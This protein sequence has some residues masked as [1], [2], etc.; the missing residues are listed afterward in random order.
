MPT[1]KPSLTTGP[2]PILPAGAH[3]SLIYFIALI[4][5]GHCFGTAILIF[6]LLSLKVKG[7]PKRCLTSLISPHQVSTHNEWR[8]NVCSKLT[9]NVI[10]AAQQSMWIQLNNRLKIRSITWWG[11]KSWRTKGPYQADATLHYALPQKSAQ[12]VKCGPVSQFCL[13]REEHG[14]F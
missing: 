7:L 3:H 9:N 12:M 6:Y 10:E 13:P 14:A 4:T 8:N 2:T 5:L 1:E 11:K